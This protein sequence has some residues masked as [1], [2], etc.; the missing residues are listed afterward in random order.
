MGVR[1]TSS[2]VELTKPLATLYASIV[3]SL[4]ILFVLSGLISGENSVTRQ[5][6]LTLGLFGTLL[7][8]LFGGEIA[9]ALQKAGM[10]PVGF[11]GF[12][13]SNLLFGAM[14][15]ALLAD[16]I[17]LGARPETQSVIVIYLAAGIVWYLILIVWTMVEWFRSRRD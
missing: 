13:L 10:T 14:Y 2:N 4:F 8:M 1:E 16:L 5:V 11:V 9:R 15:L 3:V 17:D 12:L 6:A 7:L